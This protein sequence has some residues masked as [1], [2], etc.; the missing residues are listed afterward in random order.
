MNGRFLRLACLGLVLGLAPRC[1]TSTPVGPGSDGTPPENPSDE[2]P[3]PSISGTVI[4]DGSPLR[5]VRVSA[6]GAGI[7]RTTYSWTAGGFNFVGLPPGT[8][9]VTAAS[10]VAGFECET[11][12][13]DVQATRTA[14][15]NIS[16]VDLRGTITGIVTAGG[17]PLSGIRVGLSLPGRAAFTDEQ[18]AFELPFVPA[19]EYLVTAFPQATTCES[20]SARLDADQTVFVTVVCRP[21]GQ[22]W[23]AVR[24]HEGLGIPATVTASGTVSH[25]GQVSWNAG[26]LFA[27]LLPGEYVLTA[28]D[29]FGR[30]EPVSTTVEVARVQTLDI[31]CDDFSEKDIQGEWSLYLP[32]GD[33]FGETLYSQIGTCPPLPTFWEPRRVLIAYDPGGHA[34]TLTGLDPDL[35]IVG[36]FEEPRRFRG[37]GSVDRADGSSVRSEVSGSFS[38][39]EGFGFF[40]FLTREHRDAVGSLVCTEV[41]AADGGPRAI[42]G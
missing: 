15:A 23:V 31:V 16:C 7:L 26:F 28:S 38:Y 8:Y 10:D 32:A 24:T 9:S 12:S 17:A 30:C 21:T 33:D 27:E 35:A 22:I 34:V 14:T 20:T 40:G 41:Y 29:W 19:G 37:T 6:T 36:G 25:E 18:G 42:G 3:V 2:A 13:A 39:F 11:A 1:D 4:V 5:G